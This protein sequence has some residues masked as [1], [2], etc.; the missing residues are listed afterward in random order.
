MW[1]NKTMNMGLGV[2][3]LPKENC[4]YLRTRIFLR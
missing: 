1:D 4:I 2:L 3:F